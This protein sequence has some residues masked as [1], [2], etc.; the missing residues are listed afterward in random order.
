MPQ[1]MDASFHLLWLQTLFDL[2]P[3][4]INTASI[5]PPYRQDDASS[6]IRTRAAGPSALPPYGGQTSFV[7]IT[8]Q[9]CGLGEKIWVR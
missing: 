3:L 2:T 8:K 7:A 9:M 1:K 5:T 4:T 6:K